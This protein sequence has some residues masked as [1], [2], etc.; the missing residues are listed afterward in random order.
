MADQGLRRP[1]HLVLVI[2]RD[3]QRRKVHP[4]LA[5][6]F[7]QSAQANATLLTDYTAAIAGELNALR[8]RDKKLLTTDDNHARK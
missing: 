3:L 7:R 1:F 6:R 2:A 5:A 8:A 4:E